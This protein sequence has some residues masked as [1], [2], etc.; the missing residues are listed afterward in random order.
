M[1]DTNAVAMHYTHGALLDAILTGVARL[2]RTT[3]NLAIADLAPIDEFHIGGRAATEAF[4]DQLGI[5]A[6]D[7]VLD[8]GCGLGGSSRFAAHRYGSRVTGVDLTHEYV[9]TGN[10]LSSWV[11]LEALVTLEQGDATAT[12][13]SDET[14]DKVFMLHVGM[15]IADKSDLV[16]ELY[17]VLKRG[18]KLGIYDIMRM[19]DGE[20]SYPVPWASRPQEC[21]LGSP[22]VYRGALDAAG[23][24]I[25]AER[26]RRDFATDFF[27]HLQANVSAADGPPPLGLHILMG[28]TAPTKIRN[29]VENVRSDRIAPVELIAEKP[30]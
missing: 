5:E 7:H 18:G 27:A 22:D 11:G 25:M 6:T 15:N 3:E 14:F 17:R 4:L 29:M 9:E 13:Y 8:V 16:L 26:N 10:V 30:S 19:D 2:G 24:R 1:P 28:E 20:L 21:V 12:G 23:F